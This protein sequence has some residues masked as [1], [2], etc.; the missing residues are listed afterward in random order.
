MER[1]GIRTEKG[2]KNRWIRGINGMMKE[3]KSRLKALTEWI[4][5]LKAEVSEEP[6]PAIADLIGAY[7]ENRNR[8]A[9]S[10][11]ARTNKL[12]QT[13][14]LLLYLQENS[15]VTSEDLKNRILAINE[16]SRPFGGKF[17][18]IRAR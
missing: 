12:K 11:A 3:I 6:E 1:K 5:K 10:N 17:G 8:G 18:K 16:Q 13:A 4:D 7:L 2:E 15:I 9:W 14:R